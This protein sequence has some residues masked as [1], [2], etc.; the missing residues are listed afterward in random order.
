MKAIIV[1]QEAA[2]I[3]G[4]TLADRPEPTPAVVHSGPF[5]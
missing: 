3:A 4:M 1:T 2:G 5:V